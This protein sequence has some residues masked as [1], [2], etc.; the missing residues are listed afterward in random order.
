MSNT[1]MHPG[2]TMP[3]LARRNGE[4]PTMLP[5]S[6][7]TVIA[8]FINTAETQMKPKLRESL[9]DLIPL[10]EGSRD[11]D[12]TAQRQRFLVDRALRWYAPTT[13]R[14]AGH[15]TAAA[16][17]KDEPDDNI[18]AA[19]AET[20]SARL[21]RNLARYPT[22]TRERNLIQAERCV[23][24]AAKAA[25]QAA[26]TDWTLQ[27]HCAENAAHAMSVWCAVRGTSH[28]LELRAT[29]TAI[30]QITGDQP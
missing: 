28:S 8:R 23:R 18:C 11:P 25:R 21:A 22:S 16:L 4:G 2:G 10:L 9:W 27:L 6:A 5:T 14:A 3:E 30:L 19:L 1:L 13:L 20:I 17:L 29:V 15:E 12:A 24:S 26:E 7:C